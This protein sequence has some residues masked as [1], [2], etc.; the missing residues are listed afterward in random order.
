MRR[1]LVGTIVLCLVI[2]E[3]W[4]QEKSKEK[5]AEPAT[6]KQKFDALSKEYQDGV[7][8]FQKS[9]Q[10]A[11]TAE[12]RQKAIQRLPKREAFA[13]RMLKLAEDHPTDAAA[14]D[15]LVWIVINAGYTSEGTKALEII[16]DHHVK[17]EKL[18][19]LYL[20][21]IYSSSG[22]AD[23]LL[24]RMIN[25]NP[26]RGVRGKACFGLA[27]RLSEEPNGVKDKEADR[28]FEDVEKK[29]AD[30]PYFRPGMTLG[31]VAKQA[32]QLLIGKEAPEIE[33]ADIDGKKFKLSEYRGK[34]VVL[35]FWGHW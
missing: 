33:G 5:V 29:Y 6:A 35:D 13:T 21:L 4:A 10:A 7:G 25:E 17:S 31:Q 2:P 22:S 19:P 15:A 26:N 9:Y 27:R 20:S 3:L 12:E 16:A 30:I 1:F 28:F 14:V 8:D 11:K 24:R 23:K 34:V 18:E 32:R